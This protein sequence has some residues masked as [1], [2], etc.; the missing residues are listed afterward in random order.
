[1]E[2]ELGPALH[3]LEMKRVMEVS[4]SLILRKAILHSS[5]LRSTLSSREEMH[6]PKAHCLLVY[7]MR[8]GSKCGLKICRLPGEAECSNGQRLGEMGIQKSFYLVIYLGSR[9]SI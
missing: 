7:G 9:Q 1:M 3:F 2:L 4:V 8:L 6:Q 5:R